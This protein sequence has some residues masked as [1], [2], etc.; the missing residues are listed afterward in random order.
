MQGFQNWDFLFRCGKDP[1]PRVNYMYIYISVTK[2]TRSAWTIQNWNIT[3]Q[4]PILFSSPN[5][6]THIHVNL[7]IYTGWARGFLRFCMSPKQFHYTSERC[8]VLFDNQRKSNQPK[9]V[10]HQRNK[11]KC[12]TKVILI[13]VLVHN[14]II[15]PRLPCIHYQV[16]TLQTYKNIIFTSDQLVSQKHIATCHMVA[17]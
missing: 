16:N 14:H 4:P 10:Q 3:N 9:Y 17:M 2:E 15:F 11:T 8:F 1:E 13:K 7:V 12:K 6:S 5:I